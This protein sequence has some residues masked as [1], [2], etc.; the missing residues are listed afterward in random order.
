[1]AT[2]YLIRRLKCQPGYLRSAY[3]INNFDE[4]ADGFYQAIRLHGFS[5]AKSIV[6]RL[7]P[8]IEGANA[9]M[10]ELLDRGEAT[11]P[12]YFADNDM[13]ALGAMK[14]FQAR[15]IRI[16]EDVSM[17]GFDNIPLCNYCVPGLTTINVPKSYLGAMAVAR[18]LRLMEADR[19]VPIKL[20]VQTN[21]VERA[22]VRGGGA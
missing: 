22:S 16:P 15:G 2:D 20:E 3:P 9:D 11:A 6:H 13:I 14:A 8:S 21:L 17:V 7:T 18:L 1:M 19:F 10:A 12:C 5:T 4:R